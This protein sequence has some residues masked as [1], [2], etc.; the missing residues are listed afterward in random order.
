M[1]IEFDSYDLAI[2][3]ALWGGFH[4]GE[5]FPAG[6]LIGWLIFYDYLCVKEAAKIK[7]NIDLP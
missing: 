4:T 6:L 3:V 2:C 7:F 5:W 1:N